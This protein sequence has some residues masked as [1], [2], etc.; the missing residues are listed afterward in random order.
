MNNKIHILLFAFSFVSFAFVVRD[1]KK[2]DENH[3]EEVVILEKEI[4][5]ELN[6]IEQISRENDSLK[7]FLSYQIKQND[8]LSCQINIRD[9]KLDKIK[10][11]LSNEKDTDFLF[12]PDSVVINIL[13][14]ARFDSSN[15]K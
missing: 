6:Q 10:K 11:K 9:Y 4:E 8:S 15:Q 1:L 14:N 5:T 3:F 13:S 2:S 12:Y 7:T